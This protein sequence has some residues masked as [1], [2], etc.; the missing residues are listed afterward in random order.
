MQKEELYRVVEA[1]LNQSTSADLEVIE[2]AIERRRGNDPSKLFGFEPG[3]LAGE[4]ASGINE[5]VSGSREMI[6]RSVVDYVEKMIRSQAPELTDAQVSE[7]MAAWMPSSA[8]PRKARSGQSRGKQTGRSAG[9]ASKIPPELLETMV[10]QFIDYSLGL[11]DRKQIESLEEEMGDWQT[12][13]WELFPGDL[14]ELIALF[15]KGAIEQEDFEGALE[16]WFG[17]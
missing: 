11:L 1:I 14:R 16:E 17:Q 5:Q 10:R 8:P 2:K 6:R 7:L 15:L 12:R 9:S 13:Y 4:V 3:R